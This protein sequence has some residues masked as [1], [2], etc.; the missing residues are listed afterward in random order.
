MYAEPP[1]PHNTTKNQPAIKRKRNENP[2]N[3]SPPTTSATYL[4]PGS[5]RRC[6][7]RHICHRDFRQRLRGRY[8]K[9]HDPSLL[10]RFFA[11][12]VV[13]GFRRDGD[14]GVHSGGD[15]DRG[16]LLLGILHRELDLDFCRC[17]QRSLCCCLG[18]GRRSGRLL[19]VMGG[20]FDGFLGEEGFDVAT[21]G[22]FFVPFRGCRRG[23]VGRRG[24]DFA[25][26]ELLGSP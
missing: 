23:R 26:V 8:L 14:D 3:I 15:R 11:V 5:S 1:P 10:F 16:S 4:E 20:G 19:H 6:N 7:L 13:V 24:A 2:P 9:R 18:G 17:R 12:V 22:G 21:R 25:G